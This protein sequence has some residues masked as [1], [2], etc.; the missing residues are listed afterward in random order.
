[1]GT[2]DGLVVTINLAAMFEGGDLNNAA[3]LPRFVTS[4]EAIFKPS[5][6]GAQALTVM[7]A[8]AASSLLGLKDEDEV[9]AY[10]EARRRRMGPRTN[11]EVDALAIKGTNYS[12]L[13]G[14]LVLLGG[15]DSDPTFRILQPRPG[16]LRPLATLAGHSRAITAIAADAAA[17]YFFTGSTGDRK[18]ICWDGL[19]FA[20]DRVIEDV[21]VG[22]LALGPDCLLVTSF[23]APFVRMWRGYHQTSVLTQKQ[24]EYANEAMKEAALS[25]DASSLEIAAVRSARWCRERLRGSALPV[26]AAV[27]KPVYL[28]E[29]PSKRVL[30]RWMTQYHRM[31]AIPTNFIPPTPTSASTPTSRKSGTPRARARQDYERVRLKSSKE[32]GAVPSPYKSEAQ[33]QEDGGLLLLS[34]FLLFPG[35][36]IA[37]RLR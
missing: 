35:F 33:L 27:V 26:A 15:G 36:P 7:T 28:E 37:L 25:Q 5:V 14:H 3:F 32:A 19:T 34:L 1:L 22:C 16:C 6:D 10:D 21:N 2:E 20:P 12:T 18:I 17:R 9:R 24:A 29:E 11:Q 4:Q 13:E 30:L 31:E 23:R 8:V